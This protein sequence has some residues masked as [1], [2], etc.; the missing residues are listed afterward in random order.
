MPSRGKSLA[1]AGYRMARGLAGNLVKRR[2]PGLAWRNL[3]GQWRARRGDHH[4]DPHR[5]GLAHIMDVNERPVR[6]VAFSS[7]RRTP[8]HV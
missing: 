7:S 6:A 8:T 3:R 4:L 1:Q 2:A 5:D